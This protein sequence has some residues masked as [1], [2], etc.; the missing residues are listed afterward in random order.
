MIRFFVVCIVLTMCVLAGIDAS[1]RGLQRS[2]NSDY[3]QRRDEGLLV[4]NLGQI[5]MIFN[6]FEWCFT[7]NATRKNRQNCVINHWRDIVN[8]E[9][10]R[11]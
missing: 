8:F 2:Q 6:Y 4:L 10:K 5:D 7:N 9:T 1:S 3:I 11:K